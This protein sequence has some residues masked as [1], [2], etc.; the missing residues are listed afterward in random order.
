MENAGLARFQL[1]LETSSC[2][3]EYG[4]GGST[5]YACESA[6][7]PYVVSVESDPDWIDLVKQRLIETKSK[8]ILDHCD[9]G[10]VGPW[11]TPKSDAKI[12]NFSNYMAMPWIRAREYK[13]QPD[14]ILIDGRFR[15]ASFLYSL[16]CARVGSTIL[17]DDYLN[18]PQYFEVERFCRL[19]EKCGR[20]GVFVVV[21]MYSVPDICEAIARYSIVWE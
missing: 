5:V 12:R 6:N 1:A 17:F 8:L 11:G 20:M 2:Y 3:L 13:L 7:V 15:A 10:P 16:I 18:R 14:V 19:R 21:H 9:V 4:C